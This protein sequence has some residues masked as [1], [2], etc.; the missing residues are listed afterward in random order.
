MSDDRNATSGVRVLRGVAG[1]GNRA[2]KATLRPVTGVAALAVDVGVGIERRVVD[3]V[4]DSAEFERVLGA[5]LDSPRLQAG[6]RTALASDGAKQL[7][8][9]FFDSGL[10]DE[11]ADRMLASPTLWRLIDEI[12][13]S[14]AVTTAITQQSLGF[15]DQ[16]GEEV[17]TRSRGADD[18]LER[19]ARRL[20]RRRADASGLIGAEP[21]PEAS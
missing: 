13:D 2:A 3:G 7:I 8:A 5:A 11:F 14:P 12:A 18:W 10:F 19:A 6:I 16:V 4:L 15:A 20:L 17:R 9:S 1:I 21:Q